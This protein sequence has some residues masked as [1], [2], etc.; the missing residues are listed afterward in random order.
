MRAVKA[1]ISLLSPGSHYIIVLFITRGSLIAADGLI[2][3]IT[4]KQTSSRWKE[5]IRLHVA[6]SI[7][8]YILRDGM[9]EIFPA[10]SLHQLRLAKCLCV[11]VKALFTSCLSSGIFKMPLRNAHIPALDSILLCINVAQMVT[12]HPVSAVSCVTL[13]CIISPIRES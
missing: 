3:I 4:W 1:K 9:F 6:P 2:L 12:Y 11:T 10:H 5:A 13:H 8:Q 7:S